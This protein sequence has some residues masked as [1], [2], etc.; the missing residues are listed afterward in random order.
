MNNIGHVI[1]LFEGRSIYDIDLSISEYMNMFNNLRILSANTVIAYNT[2][3]KYVVTVV[4]I[5]IS[6]SS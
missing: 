4:F 5:D 3:D 6:K 2:P 1:K